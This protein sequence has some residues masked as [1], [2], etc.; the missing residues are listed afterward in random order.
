MF[1]NNHPTFVA[2]RSCRVSRLQPTIRNVNYVSAGD[3]FKVDIA[4]NV[5]RHGGVIAYPTEAVWGLGCDPFNRD[6]VLR[7]L[8]LKSRVPSKGLILVAG[9][10]LQVSM[11]LATLPAAVREAI[12]ESW[13]GPVTWL[14]PEAGL[15]PDWITGEHQTV[16]V[17]VS[18]HPL[19]VALCESFGGPIVS[20]SANPSGRAPARNELRVRQY[21]GRKLDFVLPGRTGGSISPSSIRDAITGA[22]L[23]PA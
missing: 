9:N 1:Y 19:V 15:V 20:T 14:L 17:R 11:L 10:V 16:A 21:F 6:A 2:T 23:R 18:A 12:N 13:P 7:L 8:R 3:K 5:M 22:I 4:A